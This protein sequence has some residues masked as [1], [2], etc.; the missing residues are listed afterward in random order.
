MDKADKASDTSEKIAS[1]NGFWRQLFTSLSSKGIVVAAKYSMKFKQP[2]QSALTQP[3]TDAFNGEKYWF[4]T[5]GSARK[6]NWDWWGDT[7]VIVREMKGPK[8]LQ[9][10]LDKF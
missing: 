5:T 6:K 2:I 3:G 9:E 4:Y 10:V 1:F 7:D 8:S